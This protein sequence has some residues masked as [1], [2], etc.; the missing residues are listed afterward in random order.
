MAEPDAP[1]EGEPDSQGGAGRF[2][3]YVP[4]YHQP[5]YDL[6]S[7]ATTASEPTAPEPSAPVAPVAPD[8]T[9]AA[10]AP[11]ETPVPADALAPRAGSWQSAPAYSTVVAPAA[12]PAPAA[13]PPLPPP[14]QRGRVRRVWWYVLPIGAVVALGLGAVVGDL[15]FRTHFIEDMA[16]GDCADR[17]YGDGSHW[18]LL[19]RGDCSDPHDGEVLAVGTRADVDAALR[20]MSVEPSDARASEREAACLALGDAAATGVLRAGVEDGSLTVT[21]LS[22]EELPA[23]DDA[24]LCFVESA[25][26]GDLTAPL[27]D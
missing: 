3:Y 1:R 22:D 26:G 8:E 27:V 25:S 23:A 21:M 12:W 16:V 4:S 9:P 11:L 24:V 10:V 19:R 7:R 6:P 15:V 18:P 20:E 13:L 5:S 14:P 2:S 17:A